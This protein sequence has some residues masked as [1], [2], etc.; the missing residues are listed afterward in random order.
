MSSTCAPAARRRSSASS[1]RAR[2]SSSSRSQKYW[3]GTA[4]R[5]PC[6][7]IGAGGVGAGIAEQRVI[8][9][10]TR[11]RRSAASGPTWS[12]V[13]DSGT[14]PSVDTSPN[15]G[16]RPTMPQAAAGMRIEPPV[17]VPI[18]A[19]AMPAATLAADP[20]LD[21]PG[22]RVGSCG[23]RAGAERGVL[24]RRAERELVQVGLAD[25]RPR[26]PGAGARSP[27]R[28][29]R[30]RAPRARATPPWSARRG[31]RADP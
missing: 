5:R 18:V 2:T 30:R 4:S 21:P 10:P 12:S 27:A 31:C 9:E 20:P 3:R 19:S 16:F 17:S 8:D 26:R 28:R 23:L 1:N 13:R 6:I 29:A 25:E 15:D 7:G 14:T 24:V 22:D 11:R